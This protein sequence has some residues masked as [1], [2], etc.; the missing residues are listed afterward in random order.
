VRSQHYSVPAN[1]AVASNS[2]TQV[3]LSLASATTNHMLEKRNCVSNRLSVVCKLFTTLYAL[4]PRGDPVSCAH[5]EAQLLSGH[6]II[7]LAFKSKRRRQSYAK[8][9]ITHTS[10]SRPYGVASGCFLGL[11]LIANKEPANHEL[12]QSSNNSRELF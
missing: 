3:G 5:C 8:A 12:R 2:G 6:F 1:P 9:E 11:K 7:L 4:G 10:P